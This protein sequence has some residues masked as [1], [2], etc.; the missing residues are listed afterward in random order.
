M[1]PAVTAAVAEAHRRDW[2]FV[3]A[4]T[5]R[6]TGHGPPGGDGVAA[7]DAVLQVFYQVGRD[8]TKPLRF[9]ITDRDAAPG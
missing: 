8:F 1:D 3:L 9:E 4:A 6:I 5:N 2:G 7:G